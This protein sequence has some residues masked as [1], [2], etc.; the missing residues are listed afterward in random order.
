MLSAA[1]ISLIHHGVML[2]GF[3]STKSAL[4]DAL[5][6]KDIIDTL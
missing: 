3:I 4:G 6:G 5:G 1:G 2:S